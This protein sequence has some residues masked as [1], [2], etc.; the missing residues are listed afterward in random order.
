MQCC[1]ENY[2]STNDITRGHIHFLSQIP[3][4]AGFKDKSIF[5]I[6]KRHFKDPDATFNFKFLGVLLVPFL[7]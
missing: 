6:M 3:K 1:L 5:L 4:Q 7:S 2:L